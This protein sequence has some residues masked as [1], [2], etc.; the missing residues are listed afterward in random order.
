MLIYVYVSLPGIGGI[1]A[2]LASTAVPLPV[3]ALLQLQ[4]I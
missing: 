1:A 3:T 4:V 2:W